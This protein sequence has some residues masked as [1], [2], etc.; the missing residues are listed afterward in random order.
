[1]I[2]SLQGVDLTVIGQAMETQALVSMFVTLAVILFGVWVMSKVFNVRKSKGYRELMTD[3]FVVGKIKQLAQEEKISLVEELKEYALIQKKTRL[4]LKG[5][6][7]AIEEEL[8]DKISKTQE[9]VVNS[10][11]D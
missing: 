2:E 6:D 7:E 1:M 9:K 4:R 3:M 5:L 8:K 11:I 10:D